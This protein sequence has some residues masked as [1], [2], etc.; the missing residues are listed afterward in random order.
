MIR[1]A[2]L[3]VLDLDALVA[4]RKHRPRVGAWRPEPDSDDGL[5]EAVF[6]ERGECVG[7]VEWYNDGGVARWIAS[8]PF[9]WPAKGWC[10]TP[11]EARASVLAVLATWCDVSAAKVPV[12]VAD[13]HARATVSDPVSPSG[14][15]G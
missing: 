2:L 12:E 3:R 5:S 10:E 11:A 1:A 8:R 6:D 15:G 9:D 14:E 4:G 13:C 7:S